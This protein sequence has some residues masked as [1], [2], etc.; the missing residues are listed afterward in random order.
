MKG[1]ALMTN[2]ILVLGFIMFNYGMGY[3]YR[4]RV[5]LIFLCGRKRGFLRVFFYYSAIALFSLL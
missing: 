5:L 3:C 4:L 1:R 2:F